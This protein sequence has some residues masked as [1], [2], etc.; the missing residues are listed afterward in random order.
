MVCK[1][2]LSLATATAISAAAVFLAAPAVGLVYGQQANSWFVDEVSP[3]SLAA[4]ISAAERGYAA[5]QYNLGLMYANGDGVPENAAEAVRWYRAAAEQGDAHAQF[6]L[7][8]MYANGEGV[9]ED[10]VF[11]YAW[12]NL[13]G[14]QGEDGAQEAKDRLS[15]DMTREQ[16]AR[17]QELSFELLR[18]AGGK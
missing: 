13:A 4:L 16:V 15:R 5:A 8:E 6:L 7:G 1:L 11:A 3:D 10:Y 2:I 9:P 18:K 12:M 14:A 17:A